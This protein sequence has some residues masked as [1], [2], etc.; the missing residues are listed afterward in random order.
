MAKT[1]HNG[2][3]SEV[4]V[5]LPY[6]DN[7]LLLQ[8]RD[9][10]EGIAFPGHWGFFGGSIDK[11][12]TPED[13]SVRELFE[14][15]GYKPGVMYKLGFDTIPDLGNLRTHAFCCPLTIP[16]EEIKLTEGLDVGLFSLEEIIT[17]EMY[18]R[19][20]GRS[21]PVIEV[22]Y[23]CNTIRKLWEFTNYTK[24]AKWSV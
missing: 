7:K 13:A 16:V 8:L 14:E 6:T 4:V 1:I 18:S 23:F 2:K 21:F 12:E 11:G 10:K 19:K 5:V 15:I 3:S 9:I 24:M 17:K 22:P 20:M